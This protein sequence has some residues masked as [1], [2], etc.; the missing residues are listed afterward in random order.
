M[1]ATPAWRGSAL[2]A[3]PAVV[4]PASSRVGTAV[5]TG[6]WMILFLMF[7]AG[8]SLKT[9]TVPAGW[10]QLRD[11]LIVGTGTLAVGIYAKKR[12]AGETTYAM[13][14]LASGN[15]AEYYLTWFSG[16]DDIANWTVGAF[17]TRAASG[18]TTTVNLPSVT[19]T[20]PSSLAVAFGIER[21]TADELVTQLTFDNGFTNYVGDIE[22]AA[23]QP[24][25][26]VGY[27]A[28]AAPAAT[29]VTV[30]TTLNT[31]AQNG[32]GFHI[33]FPPAIDGLLVK[34]WSGS[35]TVDARAYLKSASGYPAATRVLRIDRGYP[36]AADF[37]AATTEKMCAH[38]GGSADFQEFS[39]HAYTQSVLRGM[40][41]LE[42]SL[43]RTSDGVWFGLHDSTLDRTSGTT[44]GWDP[45]AH[46]WDEVQRYSINLAGLSS[47]QAPQ[48]YMRV[49]QLLDAYGS[50]HVILID[51]K[52]AISSRTALLAIMNSYSAAVRSRLIAKFYC[53]GTSWGADARAAGYLTWGYY[54][55]GDVSLLPTTQSYWDMLGMDYTADQASWDAAKS[56]GKKVMAHT[57]ATTANAVT[58]RS[59]GADALQ[60]AGV[61]DLKGF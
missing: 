24:M 27:K 57:V 9:V 15:Q 28:M 35:A 46:T 60:V 7:S 18:G 44:G 32:I 40:R 11:Q 6:D 59:K 42:V 39:L 3:S 21:T 14:Q 16:C 53:T 47:A 55:Q 49:E 43:A 38:R 31:H 34:R 48:P 17:G 22:Q 8:T 33:A 19:T 26:R 4:D 1:T 36:D 29:G 56:Y 54:Y 2:G 25:I 50:S 13:T 45:A 37:I 5:A 10:T 41:A 23:A 20:Q 61:K 51:P 12:L 52:N 30:F 58:A